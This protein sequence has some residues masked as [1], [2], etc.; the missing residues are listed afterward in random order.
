MASDENNIISSCENDPNFAVIC[1]FFDKFA[2]ILNIAHPNIKRLQEMLENTEE[3]EKPLKD[4]HIKLLRKQRKTVHETAWESALCKFCWGFSPHD[5]WEI[6][7]FGYKKANIKVR[8]KILRE[9]VESQ[10]ERNGKFRSITEKMSASEMRSEPIGRDKLG[11]AYWI[12]QDPD[13]NIRI[14]QEHSDEEIWQVVAKSRDELITLIN[15]L[16][17]NEVVLPSLIGSIDEDSSSNSCLVTAIKAEPTD[18]KCIKVESNEKQN[19][20]DNK[21]PNIKIKLP[22]ENLKTGETSQP[23]II[24]TEEIKE[25]VEKVKEKSLE[26]EKSVKLDNVEI[27][28]EELD[29]KVEIL[30]I[31]KA[32]EKEEN[33]KTDKRD[34][35]IETKDKVKVAEVK[36]N[37]VKE[38]LSNKLDNI[39][40]K[41]PVEEEEN[42]EGEEEYDEEIDEEGEEEEDYEEEES[43]EEGEDNEEE[44]EIKTNKIISVSKSEKAELKNKKDDDQKSFNK[45]HKEKNDI[46]KVKPL[47]I[48]QS[49]L[50]SSPLPGEPTKVV[51]K[52]LLNSKKRSIETENTEK[53]DS[54]THFP[55]KLRPTLLDAKRSKNVSKYEM[56]KNVSDDEDEEEEEE[57]EGEEEGEE[58]EEGE[59]EENELDGEIGDETDEEEEISEV[60][61]AIEEKVLIVKGEGSGKNCE[62]SI[63]D[64]L[65]LSSEL[66]NSDRNFF[67]EVIEEELLF[68]YGEGSG[69]EC[70]V[71]NPSQSDSKDKV[72]KKV[73]KEDEC[74][75][76]SNKVKRNFENSAS[77]ESSKSRIS[78]DENKALNET[79]DKK[80]DNS[81]EKFEKDK[82]EKNVIVEVSKTE[83]SNLEINESEKDGNAKDL[84][85]IEKNGVNGNKKN[86]GNSSNAK[87]ANSATTNNVTD[88]EKLNQKD[89][90]KELKTVPEDDSVKSTNSAENHVE[91]LIQPAKTSL[92]VEVIS[93][94]K[95]KSNAISKEK[96]SEKTKPKCPEK[97]DCENKTTVGR[98][99]RLML[100]EKSRVIS[101]SETD[102]NSENLEDIEEELENGE[103]CDRIGGKRPKMR[104]KIVNTSMRKKIEAQR[105]DVENTSSSG[106]GS[107]EE[108]PRKKISPKKI[109]VPKNTD[110]K[111]SICEK[112]SSLKKSENPAA[113]VPAK[114]NDCPFK[115]K[116]KLTCNKLDAKIASLKE[117]KEKDLQS[118]LKQKA[119]KKDVDEIVIEKKISTNGSSIPQQKSVLKDEE[120]STVSTKEDDK[121]KTRKRSSPPKN[122]ETT[123]KTQSKIV[124][125]SKNNRSGVKSKTKVNESDEEIPRKRTTSEDSPNIVLDKKK[126]I[127]TTTDEEKQSIRKRAITDCGKA[128]LEEKDD[129]EN[130]PKKRTVVETV[131]SNKPKESPKTKSAPKT[132]KIGSRSLPQDNFLRIEKV[133]SLSSREKRKLVPIDIP[134]PK[135][136][137][138]TDSEKEDKP[139]FDIER[140]LPQNLIILKEKIEEKIKIVVRTCS[141][142][143]KKSSD[144]PTV[145]TQSKRRGR[146]NPINQK[147][148]PIGK[149]PKT[150]ECKLGVK[151]EPREEDPLKLSPEKEQPQS[152]EKCN[153]INA[154]QEQKKSTE[155]K[156]ETVPRKPRKR[157]IDISNIIDPESDA[158]PMRQSRRIAQLK[159]REEAER[160]K[161]EEI[162]LKKMKDDLR[163]R[164]KEERQLLND[165]TVS[166]PSSESSDSEKSSK[167]KFEKMKKKGKGKDGWSSGNSDEDEHDADEDDLFRYPPSDHGSPLFKSDHE[168]SPESDIED[169]SQIVPLKRARTVRK[170]GEL[171]EPIDSDE[172]CQKCGKGDHPEWILLCDKCDKGYHCSCLSPVL[173]IIPEGDWFCPPCQQEQLIEALESHLK[174]FDELVIKRKEEEI[175]EQIRIAELEAAEREREELEEKEKENKKS[176]KGDNKKKKSSNGIDSKTDRRSDGSEC[177]FGSSEAECSEDEVITKTK[178]QKVSEKNRSNRRRSSHSS[179][180]SNTSS[181]GTG[182]ATDS[183]DEPIYKFRK[184]RQIN[185]SYNFNEYDDLINSAIKKD[186][187]A[188]AGAGNLGRG[189]DISTII[190]A[191]KEEK[192]R[193]KQLEEKKAIE[194]SRGKD[195]KENIETTIVKSKS[196]KSDSDSDFKPVK[197]KNSRK[198]SKKKSRKL[199]CLE[200]SSEDDGSDEDFKTSSDEDDE[201]E[202]DD[203]DLSFDSE[204]SLEVYRRKKKNGKKKTRRAARRAARERR[205]IKDFVVE[206]SE[207]DSE[208]EKP[209][210]KKKRKKHDSDYTETEETD[211]SVEDE[212]DLNSEELCDDSTS[213]SDGNWR[214]GKRK[215]QKAPAKLAKK[216]AKGKV[217][218][219]VK[220]TK[221]IKKVDDDEKPYKVSAKPKIVAAKKKSQFSDDSTDNTTTDSDSEAARKTRGRRLFYIDDYEDEDSSDSGIKPG[222]KRPDTPPEEREKFIKQQEEIKKRL[223][224]EKEAKAK[225]DAEAK[226]KVKEPEKPGSLSTVPL[227]VIRAAKALDAD[228]LQ[229]K[230]E[231]TNA[232][233][234]EDDDDD[235]AAAAAFNDALPDDFNPDDMDEESIAKMMEEEDYAQNQLHFPPATDILSKPK[236][237]AT[238]VK[239]TPSEV[240]PPASQ[241]SSSSVSVIQD[242]I[243]KKLPI[244][245]FSPLMRP[246]QVPSSHPLLQNALTNP[247]SSNPH[248]NNDLDNQGKPRGRRKKITPLRD[249]MEKAAAA[250]AA[251][252]VTS[253][254]LSKLPPPATPPE[255]KEPEVRPNPPPLARA[256]NVDLNVAQPPQLYKPPN[257]VPQPSVITR[258]PQIPPRLRYPDQGSRYF[259][260]QIPTS[261]SRIPPTLRH[262]MP[263]PHHTLRPSFAGG[264][265]P[266][267]SNLPPPN[268]SPLSLVN[269]RPLLPPSSNS[270]INLGNRGNL[271]PSRGP[272]DILRAPTTSSNS[273]SKTKQIGLS[274]NSILNNIRPN[275]SSGPPNI[276]PVNLGVGR[277]LGPR[278]PPPFNPD[279]YSG[280]RSR[281]PSHLG[282]YRPPIFGAPGYPPPPKSQHP[283]VP[284]SLNPI[285]PPRPQNP[286]SLIP[287]GSQVPLGLSISTSGSSRHSNQSPSDPPPANSSLSRNQPISPITVSPSGSLRP[288]N[289]ARSLGPPNIS[290]MPIPSRLSIPQSHLVAINSPSSPRVLG[291]PGPPIPTVSRDSHAPPPSSYY[292]PPIGHHLISLGPPPPAVPTASAPS[293]VIVSTSKLPPAAIIPQPPV[294]RSLSPVSVSA[295][296]VAPAPVPSTPSSTSQQT[297]TTTLRQQPL[298]PPPAAA[299]AAAGSTT[300]SSSLL[301]SKMNTL[302][303][304]DS[305]DA[306]APIDLHQRDND[307]EPNDSHPSTVVPASSSSSSEFSGLVSYFSSQHDDFNT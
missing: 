230:G 164:K 76:L 217:P 113:P 149:K 256:P 265:P 133:E 177:S 46:R 306:S 182:S 151:S 12:T 146:A 114:E 179:S 174:V 147:N 298:P 228:Y 108:K 93:K 103:D 233:E 57:E 139:S 304:F 128:K 132:Y 118:E 8:L 254:S 119:N 194:E 117:A 213:S 96:T 210:M 156:K 178:R 287:P 101:E 45:M 201:E 289:P 107:E 60:G 222:V 111:D 32:E 71:G 26:E 173:F 77:I 251:A 278:Q 31:K 129:T 285:G 72:C 105:E 260:P 268:N 244:P 220:T 297:T 28:K 259:A 162:A 221:K 131:L 29:E 196:K 53:D 42:D 130:C 37:K 144:V 305:K 301:K 145:V 58:D 157:E 152:T 292:P 75:N 232:D 252:A 80:I 198:M 274:P 199:N 307:E 208:E 219:A 150:E 181:K 279:Q 4:L 283:G 227:S 161:L 142:K 204:S 205:R 195:D 293:S 30:K 165:P 281:P 9:L 270:P 272:P 248:T 74:L 225:A 90:K 126:D 211:D 185:I 167:K 296:S 187:D 206:D 69:N 16:K 17:G 246:N 47:V 85:N 23:E 63:A 125:D 136:K 33:L 106:S 138:F 186:M 10:F 143:K 94:D 43:D 224:A 50:A 158:I 67:S 202:D 56:F 242:P 24:K 303:T 284:Y 266:L 123:K 27:K 229:R 238:P 273:V 291:P 83:K 121:E 235:I 180:N 97:G 18:I 280:H 192:A 294:P 261:H 153:N 36:S 166:E 163:K 61:E 226:S 295:R 11:H 234:E 243:R 116:K 51:N 240:S 70:L 160:R 87:K 271:P 135:N 122:A 250:A 134:P 154:Q 68:V 79:H 215:K 176:Q 257:N 175:A 249:P 184:R 88:R 253:S 299:T 223:Q 171:A 54:I 282:P 102:L 276:T 110:K 41:E 84:E 241:I 212:E 190:E 89:D 65:N 200:V 169:E 155:T 82:T 34:S 3:V 99:R 159:I 81:I 216:E 290:I 59:E 148:T 78:N 168:F 127:E 49:K 239:V 44:E 5:A 172:A 214:P 197:S 262:P 39:E 209:K 236:K 20:N 141:D 91:K 267:R 170:E 95:V 115:W 302:E 1:L 189:K 19:E 104:N 245:T 275:R 64:F 62:G 109:N 52:S 7:K 237:G 38:K 140:A 66:I 288:T 286:H 231:V 92:E 263:P 207:L 86:S 203:D 73:L 277:S 48:S 191:D 21:V 40:K 14:Y 188:E 183:D 247:G 120:I 264:P 2:K 112:E 100:E 15:R 6:E 25:D 300:I 137:I 255:V 13:C 55:K 22:T 269:D 193:L 218:V 98:K 258:M 124:P 35:K